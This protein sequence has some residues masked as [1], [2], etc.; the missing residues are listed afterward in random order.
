MGVWP[1]QMVINV[2]VM[3]TTPEA[4]DEDEQLKSI[5]NTATYEEPSEPTGFVAALIDSHM[6]GTNR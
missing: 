3:Y 2:V 4:E 5:M 1:W 6:E